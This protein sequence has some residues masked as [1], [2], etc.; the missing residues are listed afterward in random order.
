[1]EILAEVHGEEHEPTKTLPIKGMANSAEKKGGVVC[2]DL[3][4]FETVSKCVCL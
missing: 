4:R 3:S 1:M 2:A